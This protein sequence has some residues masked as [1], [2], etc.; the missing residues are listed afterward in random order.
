M[1][2]NNLN[3]YFKLNLGMKIHGFSLKFEKEEMRI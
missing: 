1:S 2:N 3:Q